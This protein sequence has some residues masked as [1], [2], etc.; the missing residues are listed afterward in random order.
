VKACSI[1]TDARVKEIN[2]ALLGGGRLSEVARRFRVSDDALGRH[3]N[4]KHWPGA[5]PRV[6]AESREATVEQGNKLLV[7]A[8]KLRDKR[9]ELALAC[10]AK[11]DLRG[12][13][14]G[15]ASAARILQ[16]C[17]ELEGTI[18]YAPKTLNVSVTNNFAVLQVAIL[19]ALAD[20]PTARAK[21]LLALETI[22]HEEVPQ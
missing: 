1:C 16:L 6:A 21:V 2:A 14:E 5:E 4:A 9:V 8:G 20:E 12:A 3:A 18:D 22:E 19:G 13:G 11:G 17:A 7:M 10:E 15:I